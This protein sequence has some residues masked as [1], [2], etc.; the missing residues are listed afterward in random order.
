LQEFHTPYQINLFL[1]KLSKNEA[2][3]ISFYSPVTAWP[4]EHVF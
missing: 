4:V 2:K 1:P 3:G